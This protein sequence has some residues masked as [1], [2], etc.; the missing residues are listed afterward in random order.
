MIIQFITKL[1]RFLG[2]I[3]AIIITTFAL[4]A[5]S[6]YRNLPDFS[7]PKDKTILI[8][9]DSHTQCAINDD[10]LPGSI[11]ISNNAEHYFYTFA[12]IKKLVS[13]NR[14]INT[15]IL[16][17]SFH[18][19][20]E[21]HD[22]FLFDGNYTINMYPKYFGVLDKEEI[23]FLLK[24]NFLGIVEKLPRLTTKN[25]YFLLSNITTTPTFQSFP[26][27]GGYFSK[28]ANNLSE[29]ILEKR[30]SRHYLNGKE[31]QSYST[32]QS[33]YLKKILSFCISNDIEP[34]LINTPI[35]KKYKKKIP[36]KFQENYY[37]HYAKLSQ[38]AKVLDYSTFELPDEAFADIDHL[39]AK[40]AN[41]FTK[42]L[43]ASIALK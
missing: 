34:I 11:N 40:G 32:I 12:K 1:S 33:L 30:L 26:F 21:Y 41:I 31:L 14:Q 20:S 27:W 13:Q 25:L 39:N 23:T 42:E 36:L 6:F 3:A 43:K 7:L 4:T 10:I 28:E 2:S 37:G 9:G 22:K 24:R 15:I 5:Y 8:C 16:G 18:S 38:Y 17:Y 19:L 35:N 29:H